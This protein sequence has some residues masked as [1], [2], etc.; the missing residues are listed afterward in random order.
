[1]FRFLSSPIGS[2]TALIALQVTLL[3]AETAAR[4]A[5]ATIP[6]A[7]VPAPETTVVPSFWGFP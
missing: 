3:A 1:M 4:V 2:T 7:E 6:T 5:Q